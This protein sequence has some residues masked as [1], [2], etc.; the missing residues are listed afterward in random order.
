MQRAGL[1]GS[2]PLESLRKLPVIRSFFRQEP[3]MQT[4]Q[5]TQLYDAIDAATEARRTMRAMDRRWRPEIE[6]SQE[7]RLYGQMSFADKR[8]RTFRAEM[9]AIYQAPT[10]ADGGTWHRRGPRRRGRLTWSQTPS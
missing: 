6:A 10:L 4:R 1:S 3:V 5:V 2:R 7:N 8:M 9:D